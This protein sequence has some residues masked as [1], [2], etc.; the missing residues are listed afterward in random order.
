MTITTKK[1]M[2]MALAKAKIKSKEGKP[3]N[4]TKKNRSK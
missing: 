3:S 1:T 4:R 2:K